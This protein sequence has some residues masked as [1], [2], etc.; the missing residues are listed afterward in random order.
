MICRSNAST[1]S[2]DAFLA[3]NARGPPWR[4]A[5]AR[6]IEQNSDWEVNLPDGYLR[7]QVRIE[8]C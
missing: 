2:L 3:W 6:P 5:A 8:R 4:A 1:S 7:P